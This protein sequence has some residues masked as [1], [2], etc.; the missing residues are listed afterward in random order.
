M[1]RDRKRKMGK[2]ERLPEKKY[3]HS[4]IKSEQPHIFSVYYVIQTLCT[5]FCLV[6]RLHALIFFGLCMT[7]FTIYLYIYCIKWWQSHGKHHMPYKTH[8]NG[9]SLSF[10]FNLLRT[11]DH[12][13]AFIWNGKDFNFF[14]LQTF[15][16]IILKWRNFFLFLWWDQSKVKSWVFRVSVWVQNKSSLNICHTNFVHYYYWMVWFEVRKKTIFNFIG[17]YS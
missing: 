16:W 5:L 15:C 1:Q 4:L 14:C 10:C 13:L 6:L 17:S 2:R 8:R 7:N 9:I 3:Q 12:C 11:L